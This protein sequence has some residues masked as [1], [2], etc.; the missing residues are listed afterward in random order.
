MFVVVF[1]QA[2]AAKAP[3]PFPSQTILVSAVAPF[4]VANVG[5][6]VKLV[7]LSVAINDVTVAGNV[8][9]VMFDPTSTVVISLFNELKFN[10]D[11]S[12]VIILK[13]RVRTICNNTISAHVGTVVLT[14]SI[15]VML[16]TAVVP[17]IEVTLPDAVILSIV[18]VAV[19]E[20]TLSLTNISL[21]SVEISCPVEDKFKAPVRFSSP[22]KSNKHPAAVNPSSF[23]QAGS[24]VSTRKGNRC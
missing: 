12:F 11:G 19:M 23:V 21:I 10:V 9:A 4:N 20:V 22:V 13:S 6:A 17:V 16:S 8:G 18:A 3:A 14:S 5:P 7:N 2:L 1:N 15:K 24:V